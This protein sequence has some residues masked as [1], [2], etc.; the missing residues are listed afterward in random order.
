MTQSLS[1]FKGKKGVNH[2]YLAFPRTL[3]TLRLN[4]PRRPLSAEGTAVTR[5]KSIAIVSARLEHAKTV[6][7]RSG[8][9]NGD[10]ALSPALHRK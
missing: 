2:E 6:F 8:A 9:A 1:D 7:K 4:H 10:I 3:Y 5:L